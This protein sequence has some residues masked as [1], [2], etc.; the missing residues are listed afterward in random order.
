MAKR[1]RLLTCEDAVPAKKQHKSP[2]SD[3][4]F[5]R[6]ALKGWLGELTVSEWVNGIYGEMKVEC[7]VFDG[8]QCAGA[9]IFRGNICKLP[10]DPGLLKLPADH[11][12]VFSNGPQFA[13]HHAT[14]GPVE[15]DED[16][17]WTGGDLDEDDE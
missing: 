12:K 5:A 13:E 11:K 2:C 14:V 9:G 1:K 7:H 10:R 15:E 8:A 16:Y 3:C 4:P 17:D 6:T